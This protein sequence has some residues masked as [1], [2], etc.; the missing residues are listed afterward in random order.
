MCGR[1]LVTLQCTMNKDVEVCPHCCASC[2]IRDR[3][4]SPAWYPSSIKVLAKKKEAAAKAFSDL[5]SLLEERK[6]V[7]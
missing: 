2:S 4:S 5:L 1:S 7:E 6:S 3:C